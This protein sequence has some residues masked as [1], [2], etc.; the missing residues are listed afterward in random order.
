MSAAPLLMPGQVA[1]VVEHFEDLVVDLA[2][3]LE[4]GTGDTRTAVEDL[5]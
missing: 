2:A 3:L 5:R 1:E 4:K